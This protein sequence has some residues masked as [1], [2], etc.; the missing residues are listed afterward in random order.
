MSIADCTD[1]NVLTEMLERPLARGK[2]Q[3]IRKKISALKNPEEAAA[4]KQKK[5]DEP[6][7]KEKVSM[8]AK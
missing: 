5:S 7:A 2:K 1:I 8:D 6:S 3:R 4:A